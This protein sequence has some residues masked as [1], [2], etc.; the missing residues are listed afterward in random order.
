MLINTAG[1]ILNKWE[2]VDIDDAED[3]ERAEIL[4]ELLKLKKV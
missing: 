2:V 4:F 3:W 1:V